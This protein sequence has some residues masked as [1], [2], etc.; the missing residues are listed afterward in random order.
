MAQQTEKQMTL[1]E[2]TQRSEA[3]RLRLTES[4]ARL[5]HKLDLPARAKESVMEKPMKWLGGSLATGFMGSFLFRRKKTPEKVKELKR[6][7]GFLLGA[8]SLALAM[9]KPLAKVYATK[10]LKD[11]LAGRIASGQWGRFANVGKPPY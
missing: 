7:R 6:Q 11:Y 3:A 9:G 1:Q 4:H 2:L 8:L 10:L 5:K